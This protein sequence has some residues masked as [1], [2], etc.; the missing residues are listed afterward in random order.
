MHNKVSGSRNGNRTPNLLIVPYCILNVVQG[1]LPSHPVV[2]GR[3]CLCCKTGRLIKHGFY[4][5][6]LEHPHLADAPIWVLVQRWL[7]KDC[8]KTVSTPT[9]KIVAYKR[10][11]ARVISRALYLHFHNGLGYEGVAKVL[12]G[13][14]PW[15]IRQWCR[16]F[17]SR[18]EAVRKNLGRMGESV[19]KVFRNQAEEVL[20]ALGRFAERCGVSDESEII[21]AVQPVLLGH[22]TQVPLFRSG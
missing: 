2:F 6:F 21:E 10:F 19:G 4:G 8:K 14:S 5:R 15:A 20:K 7:C 9:S 3:M 13:P 18:S 16:Q 22:R 17:R 11:D 12:D 1:L